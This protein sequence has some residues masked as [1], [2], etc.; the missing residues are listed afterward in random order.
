MLCSPLRKFAA[1]HGQHE[2]RVLIE[3]LTHPFVGDLVRILV[4][5]QVRG[6]ESVDVDFATRVYERGDVHDTRSRASLADQICDI[7]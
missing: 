4:V 7:I 1:E 6:R 2:L 5:E 3:H